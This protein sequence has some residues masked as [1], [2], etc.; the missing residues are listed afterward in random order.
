MSFLAEV[1]FAIILI[2]LVLLFRFG[3]PRIKIGKRDAAPVITILF[4]SLLPLL[5]DLP[6]HLTLS[7][8]EY[9]SIADNLGNGKGPTFC[10]SYEGGICNRAFEYPRTSGFPVFVAPFI[11][12][13]IGALKS[14]IGV[15]FFFSILSSILVYLAA[16]EYLGESQAQTGAL[17]FSFMIPKVRLYMTAAA[18]VASM[19]F[20]VFSIYFLSRLSK[21]KTREDFLASA[22]TLSYLAHIRPENFLVAVPLFMFLAYAATK[23]NLLKNRTTL[24]WLLLLFSSISFAGF[25]ILGRPHIEGWDLG[26]VKRIA[27]FAEQ[28]PDNISFLFNWMGSNPIMVVLFLVAAIKAFREKNALLISVAISAA[29]LFTVFSAF[30]FGGAINVNKVGF[31]SFQ[32]AVFLLTPILFV[33]IF[34]IPKNEGIQ[35][36]LV[37]ASLAFLLFSPATT[38]DTLISKTIA[39][40]KSDGFEIAEEDREIFFEIPIMVHSVFPEKTVKTHWLLLENPLVGKELILITTPYSLLSISPPI[41]NCNHTLLKSVFVETSQ[42][43]KKYLL[44]C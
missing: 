12:A 36:A 24:V 23:D 4:V 35:L 16:R 9:L 10:E 19:F 1:E 6:H 42:S 38:A 32:R 29:L 34:A 25:R 21:S 15:S 17:I 11:A 27:L 30:D 7:E 44:E 31:E 33:S 28:A 18:E 13:G 2:N 43:P 26:P 5:L 22:V 37:G 40:L 14:A 20:L 41:Q 39:E 3:I 8:F